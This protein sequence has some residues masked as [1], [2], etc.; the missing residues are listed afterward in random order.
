MAGVFMEGWLEKKASKWRKYYAVLEED[1][2]KFYKTDKKLQDDLQGHIDISSANVVQVGESKK[3]NFQFSVTGNSGR[4]PLKVTTEDLREDW[5]QAIKECGETKQ[6]G[7]APPLPG[8]PRPPMPT[9]GVPA[10]RELPPVPGGHPVGRS[11]S[12]GGRALPPPPSGD[13]TPAMQSMAISE[14]AVDNGFHPPKPDPQ[15]PFS[16]E[17]WHFGTT[18]RAVAEQLLMRH[19]GEG[20]FLI[21]ASESSRGDYSLS[22]LD[23]K[24]PKHYKVTSRGGTLHL[25]GCADQTFPDLKALVDYYTSASKGRTSPLDKLVVEKMDAAF[26]A[27]VK[28]VQGL[29][30]PGMRVQMEMANESSPGRG[31]RGR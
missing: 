23:Q 11:S 4:Y 6:R 2:L 29:M 13:P 18:T 28:V 16:G 30:L 9:P 15:D 17:S 31:S 3:K 21:R 12:M 24:Q 10:G 1:K 8:G 20:S 14:P 27:P 19:G 7:G 25:S 22:V 5:I 26:S